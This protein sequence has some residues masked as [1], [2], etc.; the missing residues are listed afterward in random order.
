MLLL[1]QSQKSRLQGV[2]SKAEVQESERDSAGVT[3]YSS[4]GD[5]WREAY[6]VGVIMFV[7]PVLQGVYHRCYG[8]G[9]GSLFV[10]VHN[11]HSILRLTRWGLVTFAVTVFS[12]G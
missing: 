11:F 8:S 7:L 12:Y 4:E 3:M 9:S 6:E 5:S 2:W 1:L 10:I